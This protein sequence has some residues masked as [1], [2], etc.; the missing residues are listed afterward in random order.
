MRKWYRK[1]GREDADGKR[2]VV[3]GWARKGMKG[4]GRKA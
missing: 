3:T 1:G 2:R 4:Q